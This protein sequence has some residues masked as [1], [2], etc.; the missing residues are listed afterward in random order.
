MSVKLKNVA[1]DAQYLLVNGAKLI[2]LG[3]VAVVVAGVA[4]GTFMG[5]ALLVI[6]AM[7]V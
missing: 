7:G 3:T 2:S 6:R 1:L 4:F 5:I